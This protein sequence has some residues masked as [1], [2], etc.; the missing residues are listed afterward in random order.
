MNPYSLTK[1]F[2]LRKYVLI[3]TFI[4]LSGTHNKTLQVEP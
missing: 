2:P 4:V 1:Y 3:F